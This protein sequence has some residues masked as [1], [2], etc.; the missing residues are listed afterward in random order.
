MNLEELSAVFTKKGGFDIIEHPEGFLQIKLTID[1]RY[2]NL[3][4][5]SWNEVAQWDKAI[6][7]YES[8]R[9]YVELEN[10]IRVE[11]GPQEGEIW[12][13]ETGSSAQWRCVVRRGEFVSINF[14][15]APSYALDNEHI[16]RKAFIL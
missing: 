1:G 12:D 9:L 2:R 5:Y 4:Y 3:R 8:K 14:I 16:V 6:A 7:I 15:H 10:Y 11:K 13:I